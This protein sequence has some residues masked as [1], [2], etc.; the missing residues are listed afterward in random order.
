MRRILD[1]VLVV[2]L[3]CAI[4]GCATPMVVGL[5][6]HS[7]QYIPSGNPNKGYIYIYRES[8]YFGCIRGIFV[9]ANGE[10][11]GGLNS[12]T[13]F[14]H[15]ADPGE[16]VI[17]VENWLGEDPSVEINVEPGKKYY[18]RGAIQLGI[19]DASPY[20]ERVFDNEGEKAV[21]SLT[22]ATLR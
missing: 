4:S 11:I 6:K 15:E 1:L 13:Y 17:S 9:T 2:V 12:G 14:V 10:R 22:Y 16:I 7:P 21:K 19:V 8:E 20:I 18:L 3:L 5:K